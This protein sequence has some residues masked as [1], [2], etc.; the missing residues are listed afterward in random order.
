MRRLPPLDHQAYRVSST[1]GNLHP[2][3]SCRC[4]SDFSFF[5]LRRVEYDEED[6]ENELE[7]FPFLVGIWVGDYLIN[8]FA[9]PLY[10]DDELMGIIDYLCLLAEEKC[11]DSE[12]LGRL[13]M[14]WF[15]SPHLSTTLKTYTVAKVQETCFAFMCVDAHRALQMVFGLLENDGT[16]NV[17]NYLEPYELSH[18]NHVS[19]TM[20]WVWKVGTIVNASIIHEAGGDLKKGV[21]SFFQ[22]LLEARMA[23]KSVPYAEMEGE[24]SVLKDTTA[25]VVGL[26]KDGGRL[27]WDLFLAFFA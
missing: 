6:F 18:V 23:K 26:C 25:Y 9:A 3:L 21:P 14:V 24:D 20:Y 16:I 17:A 11:F 27:K 5:L 22:P 12:F 8:E 19:P 2:S 15:Q 13:L 7:D 1:T 10:Q 4:L